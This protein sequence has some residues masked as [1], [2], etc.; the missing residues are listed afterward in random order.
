MLSIKTW[1]IYRVRFGFIE[2]NAGLGDTLP[3]IPAFFLQCKPFEVHSSTHCEPEVHQQALLQTVFE[4]HI[5]IFKLDF[6][7]IGKVSFQNPLG[8]VFIEPAAG[9]IK[10]R[11]SGKFPGHQG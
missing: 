6:Y 2:R 4:K 11:P 9:S 1:V 3:V 7:K 8:W 5:P 10:H